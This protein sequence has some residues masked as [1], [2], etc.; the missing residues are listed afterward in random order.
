MMEV[1]RGN[2]YLEQHQVGTQCNGSLGVRVG[3]IKALKG[4]ES[5]AVKYRSEE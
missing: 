2:L 1:K 4:F 3:G 5:G